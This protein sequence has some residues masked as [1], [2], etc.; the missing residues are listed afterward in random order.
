MVVLSA[1]IKAV[2]GRDHRGGPDGRRARRR[3]LFRVTSPDDPQHPDRR[4]DHDHDRHA[5]D[6]RH[7]PHHDRRQLRH[8]GPGQRDVLA[9]VRH[10]QHRPRH[11][12]GRRSCS[13]A[14]CRWSST[15][16]SSCGGSVRR[17]EPPKPSTAAKRVPS[18]AQLPAAKAIRRL[19]SASRSRRCVVIVITV[20]WTIPTF[21]LFVTSLRPAQDVA[22]TGWWTFFAHPHVHAVATTTPCCSRTGSAPAAVYAATSSTR[23]PSRS[24]RRSS[25]WCWRAMAA[26]VPGLGAVQGQRRHLLRHLRAAGRAAADGADPAAAA[27]LRRACT[28]ASVTIFPALHLGGT[29]VPVWIAHT[30]FALP[31]AIFLLHNFI[32]QLP[33]T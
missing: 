20:L 25:R 30:M 22:T 17:D 14:S 10:G 6:V 21:G 13:S 29:Y 4:P 33:E 31:L 7:R 19:R 9:V 8:R 18:T 32:A 26:Y 23:W 5:E 27:V 2:P 1:A 3:L 15:T 28:S 16:S 24:R 11:R 12:A